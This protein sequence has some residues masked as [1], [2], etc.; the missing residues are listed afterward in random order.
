MQCYAVSEQFRE[1]GV[2][3]ALVACHSQY[4]MTTGE[5]DGDTMLFDSMGIWCFGAWEKMEHQ[6]LARHAIRAAGWPVACHPELVC[7]ALQ[8][9]LEIRCVSTH[10]ARSSIAPRGHIDPFCTGCPVCS[11][12]LSG[13]ELRNTTIGNLAP[14][15]RN[16]NADACR[17]RGVLV[18]WTFAKTMRNV[19][20]DSAV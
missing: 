18:Q 2:Q 10:L 6:G 12:G 13:T 3:A 14:G 4:N 20:S 1:N 15:P 9:L 17:A 8:R 16:Y 5:P 7:G 19:S 11:L